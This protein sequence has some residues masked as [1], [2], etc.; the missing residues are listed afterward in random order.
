MSIPPKFVFSS[1]LFPGAN[2]QVT[3]DAN[4]ADG[5]SGSRSECDLA[6]DPANPQNLIAVSKRFIDNQNYKF[7]TA[8][9]YSQDEGIS[10][11]D[12]ADLWLNKEKKWI[13]YTDPALAF[14]DKSNAFLVSEPLIDVPP[15]DEIEGQGMGCFRSSNEGASWQAPPHLWDNDPGSDKQW[16]TSDLSETSP[17]RGNVYACWGALTPLRFARSSDAGNSWQGIGNQQA[18]ANV[19][20]SSVYAPA[21]CVS[22]DGTIHIAWH[23][24][25]STTVFYVESTDGGKSFTAPQAVVSGLTSITNKFP[26]PPGGDFPVF[27][28]GRFRVMTLVSIAPYGEHG[29][30]IAWADARESHARIYYR[31]RDTDGTWTGDPSGH[32]L[33]S[34]V[35]FD[36]SAPVQHFHPQLAVNSTGIIACAFYEFGRKPPG[37]SYRI[38]VKMV[39]SSHFFFGSLPVEFFH[40]ARVTERAWDPEIDAP[41]SHGN[42]ANTFI[43]EYFGLDGAGEDFGVLWTDTRTG[44]QELWFSRVKTRRSSRRPKPRI[45]E[46]VGSITPGV[47]VDGGGWIW[48]NGVPH[49]VP[50]RGP[51]LEILELLGAYAIVS[52]GVGKEREALGKQ[53]MAAIGRIAAGQARQRR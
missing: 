26:A 15:P 38:D 32:P 30:V 20:A 48:I 51:E 45:P 50:P 36:D 12:S 7:T 42:P 53:I 1:G 46:I 49:P 40:L 17:H 41:L 28:G 29:C 2:V 13:G 9:A 11:T 33:L 21:I 16:V 3:F 43:G 37:N 22:G 52:A 14:D 23:I 39:S 18:G 35:P 8:S 34:N 47:A 31:V 10:W 24:P 25:G 19:T 4:R 5:T 27:P 44:K 6:A